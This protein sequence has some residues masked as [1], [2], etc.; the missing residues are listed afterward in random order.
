MSTGAFGYPIELAAPVAIAEARNFARRPSS[1]R[2]IMF[3]CF[4]SE[5]FAVYQKLLREMRA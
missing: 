1:L 3:C 5:D 4:S 2:E